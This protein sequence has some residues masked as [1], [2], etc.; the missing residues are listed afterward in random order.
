LTGSIECRI[1]CANVGKPWKRSKIVLTHRPL[2]LASEKHLLYFPVTEEPMNRF[3]LFLACLLCTITVL[4]CDGGLAPPSEATVPTS[5]S[6]SGTIT[7]TH[8]EVVDTLI[9][10]RLVAFTVF[11]PTDIIG[12]ILAG[13][14]VVYPPLGSSEILADMGADSIHYTFAVQA[15]TYP[16]V[17]V[18]HQFGPDVFNDWRPVGQYDLDTNLTVPEEV[19]VNAG[20][21]TPGIDI[22]VD[23]TN[24]PPFPGR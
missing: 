3:F 14:A 4:S 22:V 5:G 21:D 6:F 13:R 20:Q 23:F 8:W 11:P 10:L 12:D 19:V 1:W 9:D 24:P 15:G 17:A 18:A 2:Y 7:F 16:Y